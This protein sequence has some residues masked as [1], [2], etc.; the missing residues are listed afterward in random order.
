VVELEP[1]RRNETLKRV[2]FPALDTLK[3][4]AIRHYEFDGKNLFFIPK[5]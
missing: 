5:D 1:K 2:V 4:E 3:G